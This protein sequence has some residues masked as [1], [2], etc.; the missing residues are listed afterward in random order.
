[1]ASIAIGG[2]TLQDIGRMLGIGTGPYVDNPSLDAYL[3]AFIGGS[4]LGVNAGPTHVL[5][6]VGY[7]FVS[8]EV[9]ANNAG[10]TSVYSANVTALIQAIKA[11]GIRL[12]N[13]EPEILVL[14]SPARR[15]SYTRLN[16]ETAERASAEAAAAEDVSFYSLL[17]DTDPGTSNFEA[18]FSPSYTKSAAI[19]SVAGTTSGPVPGGDFLHPS[20]WAQYV[21]ARRIWEAGCVACGYQP[22]SVLRPGPLPELEASGGKPRRGRWR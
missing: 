22:I 14:F 6:Q 13:M 8:A 4:T 7:N 3:Q 11:A 2:N 5:L 15:T 18:P 9:T 10:D 21:L 19:G 16:I 1:M 17:S 12:N 20:R